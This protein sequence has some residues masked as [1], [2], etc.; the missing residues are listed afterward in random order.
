[1][2]EFETIMPQYNGNPMD[3]SVIQVDVPVRLFHSH[4]PSSLVVVSDDGGVP[5]GTFFVSSMASRYAGAHPTS[6]THS[7]LGGY[8]DSTPPECF[9]MIA[10]SKKK[11]NLLV[12][13][14]SSVC[15][16]RSII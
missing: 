14:Y 10:D 1:M 5:S 6:Q 2:I 4:T 3:L 9:K 8:Y 15:I 13:T 11:D 12:D 7:W 16:L